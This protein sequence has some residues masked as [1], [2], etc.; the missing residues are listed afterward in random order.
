MYV[1]KL[2]IKNFRNFG[3]PPFEMELRPFTLILGENNIGKTNL[4]AA[5][6]LVYNQEISV[7]QSRVLEIEDFNYDAVRSFKSQVADGSVSPDKVIFPEIVIDTTLRDI[8]EDQHPVVGDWYCNTDLT[9]ARITYRF[10]V[11]GNFNR[12]K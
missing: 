3:D 2:S 9:E 12:E 7:L 4:L 10:A 6:A 5:V 8:T 11:R 1:S